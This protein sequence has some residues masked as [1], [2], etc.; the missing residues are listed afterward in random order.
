MWTSYF[1][2][3]DNIPPDLR[4]VAISVG[5]PRFGRYKGDREPR[6]APTRA[7]LQMSRADYDRAFVAILDRL[8]PRELYESLGANAV[9]LCFEKPNIWC[10]R[11]LVA[12]RLE[13][14]LGIFVPELGLERCQVLPYHELPAAPKPGDDPLA[15][16]PGRRGD[17]PLFRQ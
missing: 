12:E 5:L 15:R 4:P 1:G 10:H 3:L 11:R 9:L 14:A 16:R 13:Q 17:D 6:L 2:N 7:M 8:N